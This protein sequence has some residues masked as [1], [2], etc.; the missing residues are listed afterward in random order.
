MAELEIRVVELERSHRELRAALILA[1]RR[2]QRLR[3][4]DKTLPVLRRVLKTLAPSHIENRQRLRFL[5]LQTQFQLPSAPPVQLAPV[6]RL[7]RPNASLS[8][9]GTPYQEPSPQ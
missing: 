9:Y 1:G 4:N 5:T 2:I 6:S 7:G 8:K 3:R